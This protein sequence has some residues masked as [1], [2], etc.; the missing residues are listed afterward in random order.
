MQLKKWKNP[1]RFQGMMIR[2]GYKPQEARKVLVKMNRWQSVN[3]KE[4]KVVMNLQW[5]RRQGL[6][7]LH[8]FTKRTYEF[9]F[10]H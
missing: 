7:H 2:A 8:D 5:F 4:V 9:N 10:S 6:F 1:K 3:R